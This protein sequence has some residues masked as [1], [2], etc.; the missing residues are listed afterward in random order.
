MGDAFIAYS[1]E[2]PRTRDVCL[3]TDTSGAA[4]IVRLT[5][6]T[7]RTIDPLETAHMGD[8][9]TFASITTPQDALGFARRHGMLWVRAAGGPHG[10]FPVQGGLTCDG[11]ALDSW[12]LAEPLTLWIEAASALRWMVNLSDAI[13]EGDTAVIDTHVMRTA[14]EIDDGAIIAYTVEPHEPLSSMLTREDLFDPSTVSKWTASPQEFSA[15]PRQLLMSVMNGALSRVA[16]RLVE[17]PEEKMAFRLRPND[18][19][20]AL[21]TQHALSI[22]GGTSFKRCERNGCNE[23][24]ARTPE[25]AR[26]SKKY[27]SDSCKTAVWRANNP[28]PKGGGPRR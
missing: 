1:S 12:V 20:G 16:P 18:L 25:V 27:C 28:K 8:A 7:A 5:G 11:K 15:L 24:F 19:W 4:F 17:G 22:S 26:K 6:L 21:V 23:Y 2:V 10:G 3:A 13:T 9:R 14:R